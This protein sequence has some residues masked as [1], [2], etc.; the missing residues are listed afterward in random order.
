MTQ[1]QSFC[2]RIQQV[3]VQQ[4]PHCNWAIC[5]HRGRINNKNADATDTQG[6]LTLEGFYSLP[7][8][9]REASASLFNFVFFFYKQHVQDIRFP[10]N[11]DCR[12]N[13]MKL[14]THSFSYHALYTQMLTDVNL[15]K[16]TIL[17]CR[18]NTAFTH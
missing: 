2:L 4:L 11:F 16:T 14:C 10:T 3:L 15:E 13:Y 17:S 12:I 1:H 9:K 7:T 18:G 8:R 5:F 6:Q